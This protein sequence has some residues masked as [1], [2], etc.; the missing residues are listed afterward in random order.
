M[1]SL[2]KLGARCALSVLGDLRPAGA[3]FGMEA[4]AVE[5]SSMLKV[6]RPGSEY[7]LLEVPDAEGGESPV[8][9]GDMALMLRECLATG[10]ELE[11]LRVV[12]VVKAA[13]QLCRECVNAIDGHT[14][15]QNITP[16]R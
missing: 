8:E 1:P 2:L 4:S 6:S 3:P 15:N 10:I 12:W 11:R 14:N 7:C 5:G 9:D 13:D 16:D